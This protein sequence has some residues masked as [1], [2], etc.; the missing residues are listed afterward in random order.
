MKNLLF[1]F[2]CCLLLNSCQPAAETPEST[3]ETVLEAPIDLAKAESEVKATMSQFHQTLKDKDATAM[4]A[5]LSENGLFC[6]TD[7]GELWGKADLVKTMGEMAEAEELQFD[8]TVNTQKI[9]V[10]ADGQSAVVL[11]Q[12]TIDFISPHI[13]V[14]Q[15]YQLKKS[16][17]Q[18]LMDFSSVALIPIN[19]DLAK[20]NAVYE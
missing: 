7:P 19:E 10:A 8:Y 20:I 9:R 2:L 18:W 6:G 16:D 12:M 1:F 3:A 13:P 17:G 4:G 15:V 5:L 11:E 14:R